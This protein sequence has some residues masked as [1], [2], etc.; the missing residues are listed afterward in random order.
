VVVDVP[1]AW[2]SWAR[3]IMCTADDVVIVATPDLASLRNTKNMLDVLKTRRPHDN[4]PLLILNQVGVP[5]RPEI[6][7]KEF[8]A[9]MGQ[10]PALMIPFD[11][12]LFGTAANNGQMLAEFQPKA[13]ASEAIRQLAEL[14]TGRAGSQRSKKQA[15]AF[16]SF[17]NRKAG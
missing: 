15:R 7:V 9:A 17:L 11:P 1:H 12:M 8:A 13:P 6:P 2:T 16:L 14:V 10:E 4:V 5:K 3:Q